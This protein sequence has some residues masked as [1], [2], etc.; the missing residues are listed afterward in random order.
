MISKEKIYAVFVVTAMILIVFVFTTNEEKDTSIKAQLEALLQIPTVDSPRKIDILLVASNISEKEIDELVSGDNHMKKNINIQIERLNQMTQTNA[1]ARPY[2]SPAV[3]NLDTCVIIHL[4]SGD[5]DL[6][7]ETTLRHEVGHC[8]QNYL[9]YDLDDTKNKCSNFGEITHLCDEHDE[10]DEKR[11]LW[12]RYNQE[13][14]AE[15][16]TAILEYKMHKNFDWLRNRISAYEFK[17]NLPEY[18][19]GEPL[20]YGFESFVTAKIKID[21]KFFEKMTSFDAIE[22]IYYHYF[23]PNA[24][25][26][27]SFNEECQARKKEPNFSYIHC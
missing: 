17:Y 27:K 3:D 15:L 13:Q 12:N 24:L 11:S 5:T 25:T 21:S 1:I 16:T 4:P 18:S 8:F 2:A 22:Y 10:H 14:M 19:L 20:L 7:Y 26:E 9:I 23:T 6:S